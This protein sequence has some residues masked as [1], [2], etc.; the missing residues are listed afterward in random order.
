MIYFYLDEKKKEMCYWKCPNKDK[1]HVWMWK[2][3]AA[4]ANGHIYDI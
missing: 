2:V 1:L 4:D 3:I